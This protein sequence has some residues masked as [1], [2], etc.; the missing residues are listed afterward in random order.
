VGRGIDQ[1]VEFSEFVAAEI[2]IDEIVTF[3]VEFSTAEREEFY[4]RRENDTI[5]RK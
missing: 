5:F 4:S 1:K 2:S 3:D